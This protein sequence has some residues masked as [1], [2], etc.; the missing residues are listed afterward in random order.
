LGE[1]AHVGALVDLFGDVGHYHHLVGCGQLRTDR[2]GECVLGIRTLMVVR[3]CA[4]MERRLLSKVSKP[5]RR[6]VKVRYW[7]GGPAGW[8][9][10]VRCSNKI[11]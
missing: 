7:S 5:S 2:R 3:T 6:S 4:G 11:S 9:M 10:S 8:E 1:D